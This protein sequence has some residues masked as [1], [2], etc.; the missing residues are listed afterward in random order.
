MYYHVDMYSI[1]G[2][3]N[4]YCC[5]RED[6]KLLPLFKEKWGFVDTKKFRNGI[7]YYACFSTCDRMSLMVSSF[8]F[9]PIF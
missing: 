6:R 5:G 4:A 1:Y 3:V 7:K 2:A 9:M 8:K